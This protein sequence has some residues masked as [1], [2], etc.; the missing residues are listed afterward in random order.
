MIF[1]KRNTARQH[2]VVVMGAFRSGT[3]YLR[4]VLEQNYGCEAVFH[5]YGWKHG[6]VPVLSAQATVP[7]PPMPGVFV[8]KAPLSFLESLHRYYLEVD[9]NIVAERDWAGFLRS[10]LTIFVQKRGQG[11]EYRFATPIDYWNQL[12]WNLLSATRLDWNLHHLRYETVLANP[13]GVISPIADALGLERTS[14]GFDLPE[15]KVNRM[16]DDRSKKKSYESDTAFEPEFYTKRSF[17]NKYSEADLD[18][19]RSRLDQT[20]LSDLGYADDGV[21]VADG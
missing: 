1:S 5:G 9:R 10:P 11:P 13:E 7:V 15:R 14:A 16:S 19:V 18:F 12:N 6:F 4:T 17:L 2:K 8:T 3:N 20:L 21:G